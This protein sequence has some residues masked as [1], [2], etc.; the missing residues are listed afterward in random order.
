MVCGH[1]GNN[2]RFFV[3]VAEPD[4]HVLARQVDMITSGVILKASIVAVVSVGIAIM[5]TT[6]LI[7]I[8]ENFQLHLLLT[9]VYGIIL[10]LLLFTSPEFLAIAFDASGATTRG[11]DGT[12]YFSP[13]GRCFKVEKG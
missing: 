10:Y 13:C 1:S 11:A 6:G 3:S 8:V 2:S 7:R 9:I 5:L 12:V 4:L